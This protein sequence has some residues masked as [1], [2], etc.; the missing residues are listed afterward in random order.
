M[1]YALFELSLICIGE[2]KLGITN[3]HRY[4][5]GALPHDKDHHVNSSEKNDEA[6]TAD[7]KNQ[8]NI[9]TTSNNGTT[10]EDN[11]EKK[12]RTNN[13]S[14]EIDPITG[15]AREKEEADLYSSEEENDVPLVATDSHII[16]KEDFVPVTEVVQ[17]PTS[18]SEGGEDC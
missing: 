13:A 18:K 14:D 5:N 2:C 12:K 16:D 9:Q 10:E 1:M 7:S 6:V 8:K 17:S 4:K 3:E 15:N 11:P